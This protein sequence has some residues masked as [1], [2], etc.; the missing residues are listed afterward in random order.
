MTETIL[1]VDDEEPVRRTFQEWLAGSGLSCRVLAAADAEE[2]LVLANQHSIDLAVLDWNLGAGNDGLQLLE[3]LSV[4]HPDVVAILVTGFAHQATPLDALRM[5]V[6]DYLDKNQ[7]LNRDTFLA[8]VR[9]QLD[10]IIP[11]KRQRELHQSLAAF[12]STVEKVVPLVQSAAALNDPVP[13]PQAVASLCRF[14]IQATGARDG[15][16]VLRHQGAGGESEERCRAFDAAGAPVADELVPFARSLAATAASMGEPC[17]MNQLGG[18]AGTV[19]LQPFERGRTSLLAAPLAV[20]PGINVVLE[21]FDKPPP[22][23]TD[24]DRRLAAAAAEVGAELLKQALAERQVQQTLFDA[25]A[26]ALEATRTV[27]DRLDGARTGPVP[28]APPPAA[29]MERLRDG[30]KAGG[31]VEAGA[32][33]ELVEAV[34]ELSVRHGDAAVRHCVKL[35]ES[36]R[37]MLD[38]VTGG[39]GA[40]PWTR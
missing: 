27:T 29:V 4:F 11:A 37:A 20:G 16:L 8:A 38:A 19:E 35:V 18:A 33:L 26:A 15:V 36:V 12:R 5:G 31:T 7:D 28:E 40:E 34:R 24:A 32:A 6:R 23:F 1:I 13:L 17:V 22:G 25:V 39:Y 3:D 9:K 30:L 10:R 2:A 14:L 21:L